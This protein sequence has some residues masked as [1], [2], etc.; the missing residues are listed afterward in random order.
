M[1]FVTAMFR[2]RNERTSLSPGIRA[3]TD[4]H[5]FTQIRAIRIQDIQSSSSVS[6][7]VHLW[8]VVSLLE[9]V[10]LRKL[11]HSQFDPVT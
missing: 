7:R 9:L 2:I 6:I 10:D 8:P 11:W 5:R 3:A 1:D 4:E